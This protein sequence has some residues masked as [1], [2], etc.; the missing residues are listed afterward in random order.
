MSTAYHSRYWAE[1]LT[2]DR[3]DEEIESLTCSISNSRLDLNPHQV[4][5]ALFALR[6]PLSKGVILADEV[7]LGKTIEAGLV[8]AQRWAER[9]RRILLIVPASLRT[10]WVQ[11]L[12]SKF[13]IPARVLESKEYGAAKQ[14]GLANPFHQKDQVIVC[15]YHF[16]SARQDDIQAIPW[17]LFVIDEAHRL[18]NVYKPSTVMSKRIK[19]AVASSPKL[20]LTAT[21]LQ[22]SLMELYGLVSVIDEH[23]FGSVDS[24]RNQFTRPLMS[25]AERNQDLRNRLSTISKRTLRRQVVEYIPFTAR[26]AITQDFTPTPEEQEFYDLVSS[27]LQRDVLFA[28]PTSN[29]A[30]VTLVLRKLLTSSTYAIAGTLQRLANRLEGMAE[31][32]AIDQE[33]FDSLAELR[34]EWSS[35]LSA[36][37]G[38]SDSPITSEAQGDGVALNPASELEELRSYTALAE[39]ITKNAKGEALVAA[40]HAALDKAE[41][42]GAA[43]KALIFTESRRT[44]KYLFDLLSSNGYEDQS[45][46]SAAPIPIPNRARSMSCGSS[47]MKGAQ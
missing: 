12:E 7:G 45:P 27:Y 47:A 2:L 44:Q 37:L 40:L 15:S 32:D 14:S 35:E 17:D 11:E 9:K 33:E 34:D 46:R 41:S 10:Q 26:M 13:F 36:S 19:Q 4:E 6:S 30:L 16:A 38:A 39:S 43:R 24:F 5:A 21:P 23:V 42:L 28:I 22:N 25:E 31:G 1:L 3:L 8:I 18:R 29:R 20:L